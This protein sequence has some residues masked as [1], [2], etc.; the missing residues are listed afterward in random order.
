M[1][2]NTTK[3][4]SFRTDQ[5]LPSSMCSISQTARKTFQAALPLHTIEVQSNVWLDVASAGQN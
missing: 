3:P 5:A 1:E 4:F 2:V